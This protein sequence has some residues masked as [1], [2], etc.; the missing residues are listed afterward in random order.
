M[1]NM[2]GYHRTLLGVYNEASVLGPGSYG[3]AYAYTTN[4]GQYAMAELWWSYNLSALKSY[5]VNDCLLFHGDDISGKHTFFVAPGIQATSYAVLLTPSVVH[6]KRNLYEDVSYMYAVK[7]H[8]RTAYIRAEFATPVKY[9]VSSSNTAVHQLIEALPSLWNA[10][11]EKG[12]TGPKGNTY[13]A[14]NGTK[15]IQF[16]SFVRNFSNITL[17]PGTSNGNQQNT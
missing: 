11:Q 14:I 15:L 6:G 10:Q 17:N 3:T 5:G 13:P 8:G 12:Q 4:S 16:H 2:P 7:Y 1:P 9:G